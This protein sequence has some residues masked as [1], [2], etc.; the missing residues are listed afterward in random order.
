MCCRCWKKPLPTPRAPS[1][2]LTMRCRP[3]CGWR[4]L[5]TWAIRKVTELLRHKAVKGRQ[6][7]LEPVSAAL[8]LHQR[9]TGRLQRR[10]LVGTVGLADAVAGSSG[11]LQRQARQ[12]LQRRAEVKH[13]AALAPGA[14]ENDQ[15][16]PGGL[17]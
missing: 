10:Q 14:V 5:S 12:G 11:V 3:V 4:V 13:L 15:A 9:R 1:W 17:A 7:G 6:E 2:S 16:Q 8:Q